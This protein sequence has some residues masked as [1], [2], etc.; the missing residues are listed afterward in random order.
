MSGT[1]KLESSLHSEVLHFIDA[2]EHILEDHDEDTNDLVLLR[3]YFMTMPPDTLMD[4]V[5]QHILPWTR[6]IADRNVDF[7]YKNKQIFG[8]LPADKVDYFSNLWKKGILND[9]DQT[10]IW[11]FFDIFV[12]HAESF[13]KLL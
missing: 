9:E 10:E 12:V 4:H 11:D 6:Q 7:F 3:V 8:E 1:K 13:K 2:I 5:I